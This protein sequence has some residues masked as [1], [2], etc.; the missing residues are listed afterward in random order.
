MLGLPT[1]V[2]NFI[3]NCLCS[4]FS[5]TDLNASNL[6]LAKFYR[7]HQNIGLTLMIGRDRIW[8][9]WAMASKVALLVGIMAAIILV[10]V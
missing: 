10:L 3:R 8:F 2:L 5:L 1:W 9:D 4:Y 6:E 7:L